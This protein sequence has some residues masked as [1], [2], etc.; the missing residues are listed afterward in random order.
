MS[1]PAIRAGSIDWDLSK[2]VLFF[3][4]AL[5][6]LAA[7][8]DG[9]RWVLTWPGFIESWAWLVL[10]SLFA[11]RR[12]VGSFLRG[13]SRPHLFFVLGVM[14]ALLFGQFMGAEPERSY[15]IV[16]WRMFSG[17]VRRLQ[18]FTYFSYV[19]ESS[20]DGKPRELEP[21]KLFPPLRNQLLTTAMNFLIHDALAE[22]PG[23][24][25]DGESP[26]KRQQLDLALAAIGQAHNREH[27][28]QRIARIGLDRCQFS[29]EKGTVVARVRVRTVE[30]TSSTSDG[31]AP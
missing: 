28:D 1:R 11:W 10:L 16:M 13:L 12:Q 26:T 25:G 6:L 9:N 7:V 24:R 18:P 31:G 23:A 14:G 30:V 27:P 2:R 5:F 29:P 20:A 17:D 22:A 4:L 15:P 21:V 3:W 19:G 8:V